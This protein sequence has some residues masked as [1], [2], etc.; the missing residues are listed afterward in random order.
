M[1]RREWVTVLVMTAELSACHLHSAQS[2]DGS[3]LME[4]KSSEELLS[5]V[6]DARRYKRGHLS[7]ALPPGWS[8][9]SSAAEIRAG[10]VLLRSERRDGGFIEIIDCPETEVDSDLSWEVQADASGRGVERIV[11]S[12]TCAFPSKEQCLSN[13][14]RAADPEAA[15]LACEEC[16]AG[17]GRLDIWGAFNGVSVSPGGVCF[18]VGNSRREDADRVELRR[19]VITFKV[20]PQ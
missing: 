15:G 18:H 14:S 19:I 4:V 3:R 1:K 11:E 12:S 16:S 7:I 5:E 17:D 8:A 10:S 9:P 6:G 20:E 13:A 2:Q